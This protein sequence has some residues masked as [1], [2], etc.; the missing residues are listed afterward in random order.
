MVKLNSIKAINDISDKFIQQIR[1]LYR[2][3]FSHK[4]V[5]TSYQKKFIIYKLY[6]II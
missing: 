3:M 1:D 4:T 5:K 2:R 6:L